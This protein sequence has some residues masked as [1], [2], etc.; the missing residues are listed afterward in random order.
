MTTPGTL[1]I[2]S[3]PVVVGHTKTRLIPAV[4]ATGAARLARAFLLDTYATLHALPIAHRV[5]CVSS[6]GP[7]PSLEPPPQIWL[8]GP[9]DLGARMA[10][11][12]RRAL[13][14]R[15]GP[16]LIVGSDS[17]G[18]P[19]RFVKQALEALVAGSPAVIGPAQDGGYYLLGLRRCP[20]TLFDGVSWST[21]DTLRQTLDR[22]R[23]HQL[24]PHE[25]P[26]WFD[27]DRPEDLER[28]ARLLREARIDAPHTACALAGLGSAT[29]SLTAFNT[30]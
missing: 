9:G 10:R 12:A 1:C 24:P 30:R 13:A 16:V 29:G 7:L 2:F 17:P 21:S 20:E 15:P 4:G 28:L 6:S 27:V 26:S 23:E 25:L 11:M 18:L 5:L 14:E 3:R 19:L 8:Q 22:L